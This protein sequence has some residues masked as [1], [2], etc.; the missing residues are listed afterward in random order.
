MD[1]ILSKDLSEHALNWSRRP[2]VIQEHIRQM[3][4]RMWSTFGVLL[5]S[6]MA[7]YLGVDP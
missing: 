3:V 2:V 6:T 5:D 4:D 7:Y 1:V